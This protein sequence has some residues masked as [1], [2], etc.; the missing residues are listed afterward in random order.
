MSS[1]AYDR[2]SAQDSSFLV[3]ETPNVPM[4]VA[5]TAIFEAGPLRGKDGGID[6]NAIRTATESILHRIPRYRQKLAWI[7]IQNHPV[8]VDDREFNLDYHIRHT[9]LPRPGT[10]TQLK[11]LSARIMSHQLDR[12]RPLWETWIVEGL[13][14]NRFAM[15]SKMHHCMIDGSSGVDLAHI[16]M[17]V[18]PDERPDPNPPPY[19]PR[20]TPTGTDLLRD[21]LLR[22]MSFP[23]RVIRGIQQLREETEDLGHELAIRAKALGGLMGWAVSSASE[24]PINGPLGPHRRFDWLTM[25]LQSVKA[26][27]RALGCTVNDVVLT[28]VA[29][30]I[31]RYMIQR[32]VDPDHVD[33]RVSA[34]VSVR[35]EEERGKLGNRVSSWIVRLP[36]GF[37]DPLQR[38]EAI[39]EVTRELKD[40]Q[41]ALGVDMIMQAAEWTPSFLMSLGARAASGPINMIVTNVPGPQFPLYL[42]GARLLGSY[43]MVPLLEGTGLGMAI[44]SYDG[45][46]CWGL[47]T[48]YSMVPDLDSLR[49]AI[50][51]SF[52][53]LSEAAGIHA[54]GGDVIELPLE[55]RT[56]KAT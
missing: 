34:P 51:E 49:T 50:E 21:E 17:S 5:A 10:D 8:W 29:G 27:R 37:D 47:N 42:L 18:D 36:I 25:P 44:F 52:L 32:Q 33:F 4:H 40:S 35:R 45:R 55:A 20:P 38:L 54:D 16:L 19:I 46:L 23:F 28:T 56:S 30:A 53:E 7:P 2:L 48:D 9:S 6:I 24:T 1:Y 26:V 12:A 13:E 31:R 41:Q 39:H 22:R 14:G 15:I 43:P 3:F 11:A